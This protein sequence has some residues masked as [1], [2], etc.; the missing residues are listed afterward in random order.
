M[1]CGEIIDD[2]M[3]RDGQSGV[4]GDGGRSEKMIT[5]CFCCF[6]LEKSGGICCV[7]ITDHVDVCGG[8]EISRQHIPCDVVNIEIPHEEELCHGVVSLTNNKNIIHISNDL[9]VSLFCHC[10]LNLNL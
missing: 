3:S 6:V 9:S 7:V 5:D 10:S 4:V 1:Y 2:V 8:C